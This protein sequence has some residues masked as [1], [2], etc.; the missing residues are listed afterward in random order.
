[1]LS[2]ETLRAA[3]GQT[4]ERTEL[5]ELGEPS[6]GKVRDS[7][8]LGDRRVIV[9]SDRISAFD[10]VLGTIPFKG[11]VLNLMAAHW[12]RATAHLAPNHLLEVPDPAVSVVAQCRPLPVEMVVRAYLTGSTSTSIWSAY[13]GGARTF[14]GHALPDGMRRHQRLERPI[15]T[16]STKAE[17]GEHDES[18]SR[19]ELLA[20]T[21]ITEAQYDEM[22]EYVLALFEFGTRQAAARGLILVDTKYELGLDAQGKVRLI[23]EIHTPD[24]SRYWYAADYEER[25]AA[26][27]DPRAL[28]KEFVRR[29][30]IAMGY[31]GDG[32][33]PPL[34][35]E[36]R[37]EAA[38]RYM[39][40]F[41]V[42]TGAPF[43]GAEGDP[44]VRIREALRGLLG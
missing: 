39:E 10:R 38:R 24:S 11:Q 4:L 17:H 21:D 26:G 6:R 14:C 33:P 12:F 28:D 29:A 16:P 30:L 18:V 15:I 41:E 40:L 8:V 44:T 23:D 1:M 42:V 13:E 3:L 36:L 32:P 25:F 27:E 20:R 43:E 2:D 7:F 19:E 37:L 5:P 34:G 35:D 22:A 9:V 31:R